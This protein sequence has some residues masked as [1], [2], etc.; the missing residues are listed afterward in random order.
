LDFAAANVRLRLAG[1]GA[2]SEPFWT[3]REEGG[4]GRT[5]WATGQAEPTATLQAGRYLVQA[6]TQDKHYRR[7]VELRAG[8]TRLIE[9]GND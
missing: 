3:I 5:V 6:E 1:G 8:E 2:H 9:L 4:S 7:L